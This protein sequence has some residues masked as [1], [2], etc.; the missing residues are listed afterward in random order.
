MAD[1]KLTPAVATKLVELV[2]RGNYRQTA[3][4]VVGIE[5]ITLR[6]WLERGEKGEEPY[7][8]LLRRFKACEAAAEA[9]ML[10]TVVSAAECGDVKAATWYL[11]RKHPERWSE[12][13]ELTLAAK[14]TGSVAAVEER[15]GLV[16]TTGEGVP[17]LPAADERH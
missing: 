13:K 12:K 7:A 1:A 17:A 6:R 11:A 16:E 8:D 10:A 2:T 3:C 4:A 15:L 5:P 14:P 9:K